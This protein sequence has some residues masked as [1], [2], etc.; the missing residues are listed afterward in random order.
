MRCRT[1]CGRVGPP[2][3]QVPLHVHPARRFSW[4]ATS[5]TATRRG[6]LAALLTGKSWLGSSKRQA[7][8]HLAR[9][10]SRTNSITVGSIWPPT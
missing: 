1:F 5:V 2:C 8:A 4:T 3:G 7:K 6:P 10:G 9:M